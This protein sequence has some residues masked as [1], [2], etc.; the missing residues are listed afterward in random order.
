[1]S[2]DLEAAASIHKVSDAL[3][4]AAWAPLLGHKRERVAIARGDSVYI[5]SIAN[6]SRVQNDVMGLSDGEQNC[7]LSVMQVC[8]MPTHNL[9][10]DDPP[11]C[12]D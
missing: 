5:L 8:M 11:F 2:Q 4:C 12:M 7:S 6:S 1:M 10:L 9:Y 3:T